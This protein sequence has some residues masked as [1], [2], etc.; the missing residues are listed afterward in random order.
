MSS[1]ALA[2]FVGDVKAILKTLVAGYGEQLK[3]LHV[4]PIAEQTHEYTWRCGL[5]GALESWR[6]CQGGCILYPNRLLI[7]IHAYVLFVSLFDGIG[8]ISQAF[9]L[10]GLRVA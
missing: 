1:A 7:A 5:D 6:S 2:A 9:K 10:A 8:S 3:S 4:K